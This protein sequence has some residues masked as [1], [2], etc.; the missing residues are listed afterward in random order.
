MKYYFLKPGLDIW[1]DY[2]P[3][4]DLFAAMAMLEMADE[5]GNVKLNE[6]LAHALLNADPTADK[7]ILHLNPDQIEDL[8]QPTL[9][10]DALE[11]PPPKMAKLDNTGHFSTPSGRVQFDTY[12]EN[13][14][15]EV[16]NKINFTN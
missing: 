10:I 3:D 12:V 13:M 15:G 7:N 8:I 9:P 4:S 14:C 5:N 1:Q 11:P 6:D 16:Q 2:S